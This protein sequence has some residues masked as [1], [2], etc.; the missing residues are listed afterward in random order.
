M[1]GFLGRCPHCRVHKQDAEVRGAMNGSEQPYISSRQRGNSQTLASS[2][3]S[4]G[5]AEPPTVP[6]CD[7]RVSTVANGFKP[8]PGYRHRSS[9]EHYYYMCFMMQRPKQVRP[10]Q[11]LNT[12]STAIYFCR[13]MPSV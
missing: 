11:K 8:F 6:T 12:T 3:K 2:T 9:L 10:I 5:T 7:P 4:D 13:G 1:A